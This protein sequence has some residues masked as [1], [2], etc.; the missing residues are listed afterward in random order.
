MLTAG[1]G[2]LLEPIRNIRLSSQIKIH[3]GIHRE[4]VS[5]LETDAATF[6]ISLQSSSI[7]AKGV[8]LADRA[9]DGREAF[10]YFFKGCVSH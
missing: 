6:P 8:R 7:D 5:T 3:V 9:A 1:T 4:I 2:N 10:F